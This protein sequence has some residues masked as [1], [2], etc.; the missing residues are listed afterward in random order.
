MQGGFQ[1]RKWITNL[2]SLQNHINKT[3]C[4]VNSESYVKK[5]N[6]GI[7]WNVSKDEFIF[8]FSDIIVAAESLPV[9]NRNILKMS[10]MFFNPLGLIRPLVLQV[11]LLCK[12]ACILNVKWDGLLPTE[13]EAK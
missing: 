5:K 12:E 4:K 9:I 6:L 10:A 1:L 7:E 2:K 13:F 8:T 3:S 11:K